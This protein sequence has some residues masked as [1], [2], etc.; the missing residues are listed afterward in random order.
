[1][2]SQCGRNQG[3]EGMIPRAR[4]AVCRVSC[5]LEG[6][7]N[8]ELAEQ[9]PDGSREDDVR[10]VR[11]WLG[12][13]ERLQSACYPSR[14]SSSGTQTTPYQ[15]VGSDVK[16]VEIYYVF[17]QRRFLLSWQHQR[18]YVW[19]RERTGSKTDI[20]IG[21]VGGQEEYTLAVMAH[22]TSGKC[23]NSTAHSEWRYLD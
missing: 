8:E 10:G 5:Y 1:M 4:P 20:D 7:G 16:D 11:G 17:I 15:R 18:V 14:V 13:S 3:L 2:E 9:T 6:C 22:G 21:M 19:D 12:L 23:N